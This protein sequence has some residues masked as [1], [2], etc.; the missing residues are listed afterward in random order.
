M[1]SSRQPW[2]A[3]WLM[4]GALALTGCGSD[5]DNGGNAAGSGNGTVTAQWAGFCT[6]TFTE[7]TAII[8]PFDEPMFTARAG[9][10]FLLSDFS[11]SFG[12]RAEFVYLTNVGPDSFEVEPNAD[13]SWPF[14]SN[15]AIGKGVPYYAVFDDVSVFAEKEL[16]TKSCDISEGSVLPAGTTGRGYSLASSLGDST[17]YEVILGPFSA[18]CGDLASGYISVPHTTSFGSTTWLVPIAGLIGPE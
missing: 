14:T 18:Q 10:E 13:G 17:V 1:R 9:D 8:D 15:C 16:K 12:G 11:D 3:L 2:R 6:G 7:D 4:S 5:N